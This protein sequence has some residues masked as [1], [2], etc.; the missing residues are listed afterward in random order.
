MTRKKG[1]T[2]KRNALF[3]VIPAS[4]L[5]SSLLNISFADRK[6]SAGVNSISIFCNYSN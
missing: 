5:E 6:P 2:E 3:F 4:E 1:M